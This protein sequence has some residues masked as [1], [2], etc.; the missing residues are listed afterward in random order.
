MNTHRLALRGMN[1]ARLIC[2]NAPILYLK[3]AIE[4]TI[5]KTAVRIR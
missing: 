5:S 3:I 2:R 1:I 4:E